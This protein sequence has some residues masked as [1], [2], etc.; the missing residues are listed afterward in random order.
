M[1]RH[2]QQSILVAFLACASGGLQEQLLAAVAPLEAQDKSLT[3]HRVLQR[4]YSE[5]REQV[6]LILFFLP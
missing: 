6:V 2:L 1:I 5:S 4:G 3:Y